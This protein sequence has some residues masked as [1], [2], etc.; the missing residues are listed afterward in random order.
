M[1]T[2]NET[3]YTV[4]ERDADGK[5]T[6][7]SSVTE[8]K[9][10]SLCEEAKEKN[11]SEPEAE[12]VQTF[13]RYNV[14]SVADFQELV[15]DEVE[16]LNIINRTLDIKQTDEMRTK[17]TSEGWQP[18]DGVFDLAGACAAKSERK[19]LSDL[20]KAAKVLDKLSADDQARLLELLSKRMETEAA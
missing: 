2:S 12:K 3:R 11:E 7:R 14:E 4:I 5:V 15:P 1:K 16:Q 6:K 20:D 9:Y 18:V 19:T 10:Q 8:T 17:M 13:K